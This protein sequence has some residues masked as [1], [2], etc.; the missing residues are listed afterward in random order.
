[1]AA[2]A[3]GADPKKALDAYAEAQDDTLSE[4]DLSTEEGRRAEYERLL[5]TQN[6]VR[7]TLAEQQHR[8][9]ASTPSPHQ[10]SS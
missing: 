1:M 2:I 10:E 8:R 3:A 4:A 9:D 7:A 6:R 5:A